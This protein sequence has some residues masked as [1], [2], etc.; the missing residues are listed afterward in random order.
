MN[1]HIDDARGGR[2][3]RS[4]TGP[5]RSSGAGL[6]VPGSEACRPRSRAFAGLVAALVVLLAAGA[7]RAQAVQCEVLSIRASTSGSELAGPLEAYRAQLLR[8]PLNAF[9]SFELTGTER[10]RLSP[11]GTQQLRLGNGITGELRLESTAD[12]LLRLRLVLRRESQ[13]LLNTQLATT[14]GHPFFVAGP[15]IPGGTLVV[16]I[17]CR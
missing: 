17:V 3:A 15:I 12:S 4:S 14:R 11:G 5:G 8:A 13:T 1:A 16:G 6:E 7:A 2:L 10:S 9:T